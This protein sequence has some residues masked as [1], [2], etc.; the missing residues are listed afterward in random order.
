M[1]TTC[2]PARLRLRL[3]TAATWIAVAVLALAT[4]VGVGVTAAR[5]DGRICETF[6]LSAVAGG[7]YNVQNNNYGEAGQQCVT[8]T[9]GGFDVEVAEGSIP[10]GGAPK[11]YPSILAGC[12]WGRCT[13]GSALPVRAD[14]VGGARTAVV[15]TRAP[16]SWNAAYDIWFNSTPATEVA[17]DATEMMIWIDANDAPDPI[18]EVVGQVELDGASWQVWQGRAGTNVISFVRTEG[19]SS[20]D[21][22]LAPFV[23]QAI[24]RGATRAGDYLTSVQFGFEPWSGGA[25]LAARDF[26]FTTG[27]RGERQVR[28]PVVPAPRG[29]GGHEPPA[30]GEAAPGPGQ[31]A[32]SEEDRR[33][34]VEPVDGQGGQVGQDG[35]QLSGDRAEQGGQG[36]AV[37]SATGRC[38]DVRA[39]AVADASP[40]QLYDCNST[41]AQRWSVDGAMLVNPP[42]GRCLDVARA[43]TTPGSRVQIWTCMPGAP[44]QQWARGPEQSVVNPASG[45]CLDATRARD[46]NWFPLVLAA[47]EPGAPTQR[48]G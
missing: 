30:A 27:E 2:P 34:R 11:S 15:I 1:T 45:L 46:E 39:A 20:V 16:G 40:V 24:E 14:Q 13:T 43:A 48:W 6:A 35:Q 25:G 22:A 18:G 23:E 36:A 33:E 12:H 42:S 5:A 47:C 7:R 38:M 32:T 9:S 44:G 37:T 31:D 28:P 19:T 10:P 21:L 41:S 8:A 29:Q 17:N 3:R 26:S 4:L